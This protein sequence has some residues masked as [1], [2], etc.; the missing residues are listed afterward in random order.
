[1]KRE[2]N[3]AWNPAVAIW[4]VTRACDLCCLHCRASASPARDPHELSTTEAFDLIGQLGE[5]APGVLVLAG[6]D[7]FRRPDL[8]AIIGEAVARGLRVAIAPSVTPLLTPPAIGRLADA[9]VVRIALSL[10]GPDA[11][12]HDRFRGTPESFA[13]TLAAIGAVRAAGL[14]LQINTSLTRQ[15]V[16]GLPRTADLVAD[17]AP[18]LWSVFFVVPVGRARPEQQLG[19]DSC[20]RVF[21]FLYEWSEGTGLAV[22]TTA[23][24]AYRRVVLQREAARREPSRARPSRPLAVND[25][26]GFVFVSHTGEVY[27]SGFLP[28]TSANVREARLADIYRTSRLFR[29]LREQWR[30]E[31]K[32]GIC[33]FHSLCGGS[34]AR[35]YATSGNFLASDPAC[36]YEPP[37]PSS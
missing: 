17:L 9:G 19:P 23:A 11:A 7:P 28:L 10:D 27:P 16:E 2:R 32:C 22:K 36:A 24:P 18:V 3:L 34:R 6:G 37:R 21:H 26:K 15:T 12:T 4:E 33:P 8:F 1:V 31:G 20:E 29:A 35:A 30:L 13:A 25:G 14:P 5:L